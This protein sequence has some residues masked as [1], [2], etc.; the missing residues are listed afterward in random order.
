MIIA[1]PA[2]L[3]LLP[4]LALLAWQWPRLGLRRPL[5]AFCVLLLALALADPLWQ[6]FQNGIDLWVLVDRSDSA[7]DL[8]GPRLQ[9][10]EGLL[11]KGMGTGDQLRFLD[12]GEDAGVRPDEP[13]AVTEVS[14]KGTRITNA[15]QLGVVSHNANRDT[16]FLL[17]T[18]GYSTEPLD[19]VT[20]LL[21]RANI[22]MDTRFVTL[23]AGIDFQVDSISAPN[24]VQAGEPFVLD[25]RL[26][27][28][29]AVTAT[30][31]YQIERDGQIVSKGQADF[32]NS[33]ARIRA[34][35]R[36]SK[37][38]SA[39]YTVHIFPQ[40]DPIPGNNQA[41]TWVEA[42][43]GPRVLIISAYPDDPV[44]AALQSPGFIG[45]I[46]DQSRLTP[47]RPFKRRARRHL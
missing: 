34:T 46:G 22:S 20:E 25:A 27:V 41:T 3:L 5:R 38:G 18:D 16:R 36:L 43:A 32:Q 39:R 6:L 2:W 31:P 14:T 17:L 30:V 26:H 19:G 37:A 10:W 44:A 24:Q 45:R 29:G 4:A 33:E 21:T 40:N 9:E 11:R 12:F 1:N 15:I 35:D 42:V 47:R 7:A 23:D 8:L 28:D 13:G